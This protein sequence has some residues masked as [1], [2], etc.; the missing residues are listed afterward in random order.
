MVK[1]CSQIAT[2]KF[3][4]LATH[5]QL[6]NIEIKELQ[7]HLNENKKKR[8]RRFF[9]I[10][11][12][13]LALVL[14]CTIPFGL[15][16][17]DQG[18]E[19]T[20]IER[21]DS[22]GANILTP[23][24]STQNT[25]LPDTDEFTILCIQ[26]QFLKRDA[27]EAF[28]AQKLDTARNLMAKY[29][30]TCP[31]D[32]EAQIY[33]NNYNALFAYSIEN[34]KRPLIKL[35]AVVPLLRENGIKDSFEILRG[36]SLAQY[37]TNQF[38]QLNAKKTIPLI[39][40]R[41]V[42]DGLIKTTN[43][44]LGDKEYNS[45]SEIAKGKLAQLAAKSIVDSS[46]SNPSNPGV[47]GVIG[48]F[49]SGSTFAASRIYYLHNMPVISPTSTNRRI[50]LDSHTN[51]LPGLPLLHNI[52]RYAS[53]S[54]Y[55]LFFTNL[56][57]ITEEKFQENKDEGKGI[58]QAN[59]QKTTQQNNQEVPRKDGRCPIDKG[60][61][62]LH[63]NIFR[64]PPSDANAQGLI[65]EYLDN[66]NSRG[67]SEALQIIVISEVPENST[68]S[69][70]YLHSLND[71]L[72]REEG[73]PIHILHENCRLYTAVSVYHNRDKC[74][75]DILQNP[76]KSKVLVVVPSSN[77]VDKAIK[78]VKEVIIDY[79]IRDKLI[80]F[81]SDSLLSAFN[82]SNQDN[83][84]P[85]FIGTI[86]TSAS[87]Q[88]NVEFPLIP[89]RIQSPP[90]K[91]IRLTWRSQMAFDALLIYRE[92]LGKAFLAKYHPQD[93]MGLRN[94][95]VSNIPAGVD[96]KRE[97]SNREGEIRFTKDHDRD[98]RLNKSMNILLCIAQE[99]NGINVFRELRDG[100]FCR[101]SNF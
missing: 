13:P 26:N 29:L 92:V 51:E 88:D 76:S 22:E 19:V 93:I 16:N 38:K 78:F 28:S 21:K 101:S 44:K 3:E 6:I 89:S 53:F 57:I 68:Y 11:I 91:S 72:D 59:V 79:P 64:M 87:R 17:L 83:I 40:V 43:V 97:F 100:D 85:V 62:C 24:P 60:F 80:V 14:V 70:N 25:L 84:D 31:E 20:L 74:K 65:Q 58:T 54:F 48:H 41:I 61:I 1:L 63:P 67:K 96:T 33:L 37:K 86:L 66:H 55:N 32:A 34:R 30:L 45:V 27:V 69:K 46:Q 8:V 9:R 98:F 15:I 81:G 5:M 12:T 95:L 99:K 77:H 4:N 23:I 42:N 7:H 39:L 2:G 50:P 47:V 90:K 10:S 94:Y 36:I 56:G 52:L 18:N 71:T 73:N 75:L 49:S 82:G 35:A